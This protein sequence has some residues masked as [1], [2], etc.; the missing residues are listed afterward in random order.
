MR[1][2]KIKYLICCLVNCFHDGPYFTGSIRLL[3][4]LSAFLKIKQQRQ[5]L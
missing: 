5:F 4:I 3:A 2:S 1:G